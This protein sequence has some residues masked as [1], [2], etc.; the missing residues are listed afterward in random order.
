MPYDVST[1]YGLP[2][3]GAR[4]YDGKL[5]HRTIEPSHDDDEQ[6]AEHVEQALARRAEGQDG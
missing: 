6:R 3:T 1:Y 4:L 5:P 2:D